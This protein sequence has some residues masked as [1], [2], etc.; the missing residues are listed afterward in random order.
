VRRSLKDAK[1][2]LISVMIRGDNNDL[3]RVSDN[4][5]SVYKLDHEDLLKIVEA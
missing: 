3:R 5:F 2:T 1:S 4:Y